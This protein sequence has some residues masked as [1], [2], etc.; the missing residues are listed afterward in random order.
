[1]FYCI[2][3]NDALGTAIGKGISIAGAIED[4]ATNRD[5]SEIIAEYNQ[6]APIIIEGEEIKVNLEISFNAVKG[7]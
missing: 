7:E 5:I 2:G 4:W 1:M 6:Y 3:E